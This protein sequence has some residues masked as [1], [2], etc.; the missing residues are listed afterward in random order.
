VAMNAAG[1]TLG[2]LAGWAAAALIG[3][4]AEAT[5]ASLA[6]R[7]P[8]A[9]LAAVAAFGLV[10]IALSPYDVSLDVGALK[11]AVKAARPVPFGPTIAG[12][13]PTAEP[14]DWAR[15]LLDWALLGG[16]GALALREAAWTRRPAIVAAAAALALVLAALIEFAQL[17]IG[18]RV[19]DMT[20][21]VLASA[22][23]ATGALTVAADPGRS[24]RSWIV[25]ALILRVVALALAA[26]TP[27]ALV[28]G[29]WPR[30]RWAMAVPLLAYHRRTD[31]SALGD[32]AV[33]V[34]SYLPLGFLLAARDRR[35]SPRRVAA[36]GLVLALILEAGQLFL[37]GRTCEITDALTA[38]AGTFLG[39]RAARWPAGPPGAVRDR[40]R[41]GAQ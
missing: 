3:P 18:G 22:G 14:W 17:A 24:P 19:A 21:V 38:A 9:T 1:A 6:S 13:A 33:Q 29:G 34:L 28:A 27:P 4:R 16:L 2:A 30:P 12:K 8:L 41:D 26:W 32:A 11:A 7:R 37:E 35:A 23:A 5:L 10:V 36:L 15:E 39:A 31:V 25:P 40:R 20:S